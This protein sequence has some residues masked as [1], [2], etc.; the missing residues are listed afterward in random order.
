MPKYRVMEIRDA[1]NKDW[2][3]GE[4]RFKRQI[5]KQLGTIFR[6]IKHGDDRKS[7]LFL[8]KDQVILT[9]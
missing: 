1:L 8:S 4:D 6:T 2:V 9:H 5:E 7:V 3:L